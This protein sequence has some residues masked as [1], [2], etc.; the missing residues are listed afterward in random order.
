M[1][2]SFPKV[3]IITVNFNGTAVTAEL[4]RSLEKITYP[5][6]EVIVVDNSNKEPGHQLP[7]DFPWIVYI[8][9]GENLG[10]AGGNNR[11]LEAATG[12]YLFL[13]NNDT[14]VDPGFLEPLIARM[15]SDSKIG[16]VVPKILYFDEPDTIQFVGFMPIN[17]IT[18]RGFS[19]GYLEKDQGQYNVARPTSRAHGAAML[20]SRSAFE[21]VGFMAE[22]FFLYYEEMDYCERF[23]RAGYSIWYEPKSRIWHKESI[24][25]GKGSTLKTYYY[26]RN[27]LLYLRRNTMGFQRLL[28]YLYYFF[29]AVPKN[30]LSYILK[31]DW[32]H[33]KAFWQGFV[34]N[35][36]HSSKDIHDK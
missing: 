9:T 25:T 2:N 12:D 32:P 7:I 5:S 29:I 1:P 30:L 23:K 34:W 24:S 27:R 18:G 16:I 20:F 36:S 22:L 10:F 31:A 3:S 14:E 6:I 28:M 8:E 33:L 11:G 19:I 17:P 21:K 26:S 15:E 4:L 35:F 13:L